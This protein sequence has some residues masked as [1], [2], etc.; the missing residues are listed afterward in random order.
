MVCTSKGKAVDFAPGNDQKL[1]HEAFTI[2]CINIWSL[3]KIGK[4]KDDEYNGVMW[5]RIIR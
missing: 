3:T 1:I 2:I 5:T 4:I